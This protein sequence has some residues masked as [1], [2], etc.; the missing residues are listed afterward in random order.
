MKAIQSLV[1]LITLAVVG[2]LLTSPAYSADLTLGEAINKAGRQRMLSQRIVKAYAMMGQ[3][4]GYRKAKKQLR[5]S[6]ALFEFQLG[7]LK[8]LNVNSDIDD[9]LKLVERQ[10]EEV[11]AIIANKP[12]RIHVAQLRSKSEA[13]LHSAHQVV[14]LLESAS[15][16]KAGQVVKMA[17]RQR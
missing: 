13:L 16:D 5:I 7:E 9:A 3:D 10:W 17:V 12:K 6:S 14:V 2:L 1:I 4:I 15:N 11:K 8:S